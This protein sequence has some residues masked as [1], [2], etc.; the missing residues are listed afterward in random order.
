MDERLRD[1][2]RRSPNFG[3]LFQYQPLLALYGALAEANVFTNPNAALV[4]AGQFGEVLAEELVT[5]V[6]LRVDGDR[7][8]DRLDALT[9][10][11]ALTPEVRAAFDALRT[12]RNSAAHRHLFDT[13]RALKA[14]E[15]SYELGNW[16]HLAISGKRTVRAFV[17]PAPP[18]AGQGVS[19]PAEIAELREALEHHRQALALS[20]TKLA[21]TR[22]QQ[23]EAGRRAQDEAAQ[24]VASSAAHQAEM[25]SR[26]EQLEA[27][28]IALRAAQRQDYDRARRQPT[29]VAR[30]AREAIV[31]RAQRPKPL[32]EIQAREVIDQMLVEAGW[33]IQDREDLNP[34]A[35]RGVAVREFTL[36][37]GRADYVLYVDG[38]IVG[39]IEAK[40]EGE[41][42]SRA[43]AQ[44]DRYA[45]GVLKEFR[46]AVWREDEP[47]AFRYATTGS[48]TYFVNRLDPDSRSRQ[49]FAFHRPETVAA[50]MRRAE[51]LPETP[52]LRA[53]LRSLPPL[54]TGGLRPAQIEAIEGLEGS[55]AEDRPRALIQMA[56]GAGKTVTAV[57]ETYRLL[58]YAQAKR[59][60]FLVDRNNLAKQA[61]AEFRN[62]TTPDDGRKFSE[63]YGVD[64][65]GAAGLQETSSVV[66]CTIQKMYSL[67]R[68][69][70]LIDDDVSDDL[71]DAVDDAF[72]SGRPV[73]V[74][75]NP[76]VPIE[77]FDLIVVDECH[78]SIYGLWRGVLE[79][80]DAHLVGLTATPTPQT[81]GFF[82]QNLV[83]SY[84]FAKAVADGVNVDFDVVELFTD[85]HD[86]GATIEAGTTVPILERASRRRRL[87][88]LED[89]FSYSG[90]QLGR[91]VIAEDDIRT[92]LQ[93][94]RDNWQRW[95]P[96]RKEVPKTLIFAVSEAHAEEVLK[97][98][99]EVFGRGDDFAAKITYKSR[100]NGQNPDELINELRNSP[101]LRIAVTV[102]MIAT[103]TDVRALECVIFMRSVKSAVLF[104]Q[105]KGRGARSID[106][107]ELRE[108]TPGADESVPPVVKDR[109]LL[110]DAAG[111]TRSQLVDAAPLPTTPGM[112]LQKL[113]DRAGSGAITAEETEVLAR[114]LGR[115]GKQLTNEQHEII[116][117][118]AGG[119]TLAMITRWLSEAC[120]PFKQEE[121]TLAEG[122]EAAR[123]LIRDA[124]V[125]L[126]DAELRKVITG[127]RRDEDLTIDEVT[128]A[129]ITTF[130]EV[131]R[132]ERARKYITDWH[133]LLDTRRDELT[134]IEIA[135][136]QTRV[137][138]NAAYAALRE[139][140]AYIKRPQYDW[141]PQIL[142][143]AYEDLGRATAQHGKR[144]GIPDLISLIRYELG[145]EGELR[146]YR[147]SVEER[148]AGWI[149]RQQ[150][151]GA[152]Y[153]SDQLWWLERICDRVASDIGVEVEALREE[154]FTER[155]GSRGFIAAFGGDAGAARKLLTELN[156]E[157]A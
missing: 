69:Q 19:N 24:L 70:P 44:N 145:A 57:T 11:G 97:Q 51:D 14:V 156:Q 40:R 77:S 52:T 131:P 147:S 96:G 90:K 137:A 152:T 72:E 102:D 91:N 134:A 133:S 89:D 86:E 76:A 61:L 127:I 112:S 64:R 42:L 94:Y 107:T 21:E 54:E 105:M 143:Q 59:V 47:F 128:V 155:G 28:I 114:K 150:Q 104:E 146:P 106:E 132:E 31:E 3:V 53:G 115:L 93:T 113:L 29:S 25:A 142:W 41:V 71:E 151:A 48:E 34:R 67:L 55:L 63:L 139:L 60:L 38:A 80:F 149:L 111:V 135:L 122:P 83:S 65:L 124:V 153:S 4:Q 27:E 36:A 144:A 74:A 45:R 117:H 68:G 22:Q 140:A 9:R 13:V 46:L 50:W 110:I 20:R 18:V 26:I 56:T 129:T 49:V 125:P 75:Y 87:E 30:A 109:F 35:D 32:S 136:G 39:V 10:V 141:T 73:E 2:A 101:Q 58:K 37:T 7:Q 95:F 17:P 82:G 81:K 85:I 126:A 16:F 88:E 121:T 84:S 92:V 8:V 62:Y 120:D 6:G 118:A 148:F 123:K 100:Q 33:L 23:A 138:P 103:G 78:R 119:V 116:T 99:K 130:R 98:A 79:Y 15:T 5:R 154:P 43:L 12:A 157:L 108:V 66:I 1:L